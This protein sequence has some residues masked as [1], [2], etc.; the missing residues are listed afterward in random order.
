MI[1]LYLDDCRRCPAGFSLA[2][3]GEECLMMLRECKVDILSLDYELG[4][5]SNM[6]GRDVVNAIIR[7]QLYPKEI[8]LHTSSLFGKQEMY[9][10]LY[11]HKPSEVIL[12]N[13]PMST[14]LLQK[15]AA[16]HV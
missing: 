10:L 4:F 2:R 8:Y 16:E 5:E 1:H 7:E 12:H 11:E 13:G 3:S 6:C 15:I 14:E 9:Q